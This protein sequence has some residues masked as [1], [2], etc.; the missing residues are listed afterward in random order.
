MQEYEVSRSRTHTVLAFNVLSFHNKK[1]DIF[2]P[3][4]GFVALL[5]AIV[6]ISGNKSVFWSKNVV[7]SCGDTHSTFQQG[8]NGQIMATALLD[9]FRLSGQRA[10]YGKDKRFTARFL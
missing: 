7:E 5:T 6:G 8:G 3:N 4:D 9:K 10:L 2:A 1:Q